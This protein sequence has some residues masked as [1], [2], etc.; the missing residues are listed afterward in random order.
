MVHYKTDK[1]IIGGGSLQYCTHKIFEE[2]GLQ[3]REDEIKD[4]D[5][6]AFAYLEDE[7]ATNFFCKPVKGR[8]IDHMFFEYKKNG[9]LKKNSVSCYAR[10]YADTYEEAVEGFNILIQ[11]RIKRL[12]EETNRVEN[13]LIE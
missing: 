8:I 4:G 12:K 6:F 5:V 13:L 9:E 1:Y 10:I 7:R 11:N 2:A 3:Y